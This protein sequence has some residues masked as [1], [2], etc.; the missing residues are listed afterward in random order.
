MCLRLRT[1]ADDFVRRY[2]R[3]VPYHDGGE[4]LC[5]AE[6]RNFDCVLWEGK[7]TAYEARPVQCSTY[8]FWPFIAGSER[9]WREE[10]RECPGIGRGELR[11]R[12]HIDLCMDSYRR[13]R[14]IRR[15]R[16]D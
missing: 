14:P 1:T 2:C 12:E 8:P 6:K 15:P 10:S 13:N 3:W 16:E 7:C 4:V 9:S 5:L 11:S